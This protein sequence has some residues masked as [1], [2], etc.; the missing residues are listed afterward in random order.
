[1][2]S[3]TAVVRPRCMAVSSRVLSAKPS[4]RGHE[5]HH[6]GDEQPGSLASSTDAAGRDAK[7]GVPLRRVRA[8]ERR[9]EFLYELKAGPAT[10]ACGGRPRASNDTTGTWD[11]RYRWRTRALVTLAGHQHFIG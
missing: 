8:G 1:M 4:R 10:A 5:D 9:E 11:W 2:V 6:Q 3:L 7:H